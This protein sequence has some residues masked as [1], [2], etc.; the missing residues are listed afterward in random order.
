MARVLITEQM[1]P[2]AAEILAERGIAVDVE[3]GLAADALKARI[4]PY[5][6]LVV[7]PATQVDVD[8]LEAAANLQVIGRAGTSVAQLGTAAAPRPRAVAR[9]RRVTFVSARGGLTP[10]DRFARY[11]SESVIREITSPRPSSLFDIKASSWPFATP[12]AT[13]EEQV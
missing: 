11:A 1:S 4:G 2:R 10:S 7:R 12:G 3:P 8:L 9:P 13:T 5:D 6:G